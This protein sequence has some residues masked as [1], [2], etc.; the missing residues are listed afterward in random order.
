M[1]AAQGSGRLGEGEI[2]LHE[3]GVDPHL[4]EAPFV[5]VLAKEAAPI[6]KT[7]GRKHKMVFSSVGSTRCSL[8]CDLFYHRWNPAL[9]SVSLERATCFDVIKLRAV[10]LLGFGP[11]LA[12]PI[13]TLVAIEEEDIELGKAAGSANFIGWFL[14]HSCSA[15]TMG[16][17]SNPLRE[18][19][20]W[21]Q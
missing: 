18:V 20:L 13:N 16:S 17:A 10:V 4:R 12:H 9:L 6:L 14:R 15:T 19:A 1:K 8:T 3:V 7:P 21:Q 11:C 2:V 5:V